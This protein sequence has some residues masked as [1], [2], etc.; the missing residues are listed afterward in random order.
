[1][2]RIALLVCALSALALLA[3]A[4]SPARTPVPQ[5]KLDI[6]AT[7]FPPFDFAREAGG[8]WAEVSMLLPPGSESHTYEPT[9]KD[10][11]RIASCDLFIY[12][13]GPSDAWVDRLLLAAEIDPA[14]TL[15]MMDFVI[16]LEEAEEGILEGDDHDDHEGHVHVFDEHIWTDP[17]NAAAIT[18]GI[19]GRLAVLDPDHAQDY[20]ARAEAYGLELAKI[21][22][23]FRS[24]VEEGLRKE[25]IVAD[26]FPLIYFTTAYGLDYMAAFPGCAAETDAKPRTVA[27]IIEKV[28]EEKIPYVFHIEF[29]NEKLADLVAESTGAEKLLFHTAHNVSREE[30]AAGATYL[31]LMRQ[32]AE[33]LRKGLGS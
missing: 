31:S 13:G 21:D 12:N 15:R 2:K 23:S 29:S 22:E 30:I 6:I 32:N 27:A 20:Q 7:T 8:Q 19:A 9:P 28:R 10:V 33:N 4:C 24:I 1:M 25:I 26:R 14:K 17:M 3:P 18:R 11:V 16:L 5:G